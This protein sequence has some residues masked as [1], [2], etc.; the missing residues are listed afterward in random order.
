MKRYMIGLI[1]LI[2]LISAN[3]ETL[4]PLDDAKKT[5][6]FQGLLHE[7]R[8][9]VCQNQDLNDSNAPLAKDLKNEVYAL[10]KEGHSDS[11]IVQY[12]TDRYGDFILFKPPLKSVTL[13]LWLA[14][15]CFLVLGLIVL[16]RRTRHA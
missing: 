13:V 7:L 3:A 16:Y 2:W 10:V 1:G 15:L 6:Q 4:Y 11:E 5:A 8:C 14:P 9:L 12:L